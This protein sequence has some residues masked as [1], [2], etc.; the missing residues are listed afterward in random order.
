MT[1]QTFPYVSDI[2]LRFPTPKQAADVKRVLEVD[3]ELG[4]RVVKT[5]HV[6]QDDECV[7]RV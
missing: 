5:F 7:L 6:V 1:D 4:D 2:D 3:P